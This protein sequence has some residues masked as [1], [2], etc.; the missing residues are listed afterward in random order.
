MRD[1][2]EAKQNPG[3]DDVGP[4]PASALAVRA[5]VCPEQILRTHQVIVEDPAGDVQQIAD[6]RVAHRVAPT[7]PLLVPEP[8]LFARST[9]SCCDTS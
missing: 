3:R 6:Q 7:H 5:S 2:H 8:M 9:A 4:H 1:R